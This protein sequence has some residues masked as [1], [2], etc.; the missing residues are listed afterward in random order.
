MSEHQDETQLI[1]PHT[2]RP[3]GDHGTGEQAIRWVLHY[4][5]LY[6]RCQPDQFLQGWEEGDLAEY[7]EFYEWLEK[8]TRAS[9]ET[10]PLC[11]VAGWPP[12][13]KA[14]WDVVMATEINSGKYI[15]AWELTDLLYAAAN[16]NQP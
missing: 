16:G 14:I 4:A 6:T 8:Q 1:D 12:L 10:E 9:S 5:D 2:G 15:N 3:V 13:K 7:P 11:G